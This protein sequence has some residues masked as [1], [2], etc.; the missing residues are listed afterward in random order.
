MPPVISINPIIETPVFSPRKQIAE[1]TYV[2]CPFCNNPENYMELAE[3][4][5]IGGDPVYVCP[6][7]T[8]CTV[9]W[10][11]KNENRVEISQTAKIAAVVAAALARNNPPINPGPAT[12]VRGSV[13][14]M[15]K[16]GE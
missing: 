10:H 7:C 8:G 12:P 2:A 14:N 13:S 15:A 11:V 6:V 4:Q 3:N 16:D 5:A 9:Q 1:V